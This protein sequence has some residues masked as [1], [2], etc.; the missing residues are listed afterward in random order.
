MQ[1]TAY[2]RKKVATTRKKE[3]PDT[4]ESNVQALG[5]V[6]KRSKRVRTNGDTKDRRTR[7]S[8]NYFINPS[9]GRPTAIRPAPAV[10][11]SAIDRAYEPWTTDEK[12]VAIGLVGVVF[13]I[14][15]TIMRIF[16]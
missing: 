2:A 11:W 10:Y 3:R 12:L 16:A 15:Y 4:Q 1:R 6:P 8:S 14:L 9:S 5:A 13:A 7:Q